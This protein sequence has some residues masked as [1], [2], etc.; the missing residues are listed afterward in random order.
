MSLIVMACYDTEDNG[1]S[2][3]TKETLMGLRD[4]VDFK[5][6][7]LIISDNGSCEETQ[8]ILRKLAPLCNAH[9][10]HNGENLG[11]AKAVNKGMKMRRTGENVIKLDND[12][13]IHSSGWVDEME[14]AINRDPAIG[15]IGLKRKDIDFNGQVLMLPH[16]SGQR[17]I[18]VERGGSIMGTCTMF[19]HMMIDKIGAM[20]QP[21]L[22]GFDDCLYCLR[23][24]LAGFWNCYLPHI[25]IDHIDTGA[26]PQTQVKWGLAGAVWDEYHKWHEEYINGTRQLWEN[27]E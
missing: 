8:E 7:R 22:Y 11:T 19:N 20:S 6:H 24:E 5:K 21:G 26:N 17:W 25:N 1:R 2:Q 23:S 14:E 10:I 4:T 13:V 27:F 3:Y 9:V 18:M 15:I 16:I 12:I